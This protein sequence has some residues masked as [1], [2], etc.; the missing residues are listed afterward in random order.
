MPPTNRRPIILASG[1][2]IR[3]QLLRNAGV[4]F[5]VQTAR[6]DEEMLRRGL[7]AEGATPREIADALA[8]AK[9]G[10]VAMK[11]P[12]ALV[13]GCDQILEFEGEVFTKPDSPDMARDQLRQ[14]RNKTH[15]LMSAAV[16]FADNEP[17]WR[18]VGVAK[19]TMRD[20]SDQYLDDYLSRN[21]ESVRHSVGGYKLEEEG[22]RLFTRV[23]GDYF[24][25]LGMPLLDILACLTLRGDLPK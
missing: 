2:L 9:A 17:V 15:T 23:E 5:T 6:V 16:V 12:A 13:I 11:A 10:K 25:V 19:L 18:H 3:A 1:S 7:E 4:D 14:L 22:V 21:W 20:F 8:E 24:N